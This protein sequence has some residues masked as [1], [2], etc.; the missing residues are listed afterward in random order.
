MVS[1]HHNGILHQENILKVGF[2]PAVRPYNGQSIHP[3]VVLK[4]EC[5]SP[6]PSPSHPP[7]HPPFL[8][9]LEGNKAGFHPLSFSLRTKADT[10][11]SQWMLKWLKVISQQNYS[12][13]PSVFMLLALASATYEDHAELQ[14]AELI[15]TILWC[16]CFH[17]VTSWESISCK[18]G[19]F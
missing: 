17:K 6:R 11:R 7:H 16:T 1:A 3:E 2:Q 15:S 4:G 9:G 19:H 8:S 5:C 10:S 12:P 13:T 18:Q 14:Q